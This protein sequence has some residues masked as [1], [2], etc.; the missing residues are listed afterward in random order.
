MV[1]VIFLYCL[2]WSHRYFISI[3]TI[4]IFELLN[5]LKCDKYSPYKSYYYRIKISY[6]RVSPCKPYARITQL[7]HKNAARVVNAW[8]KMLTVNFKDNIK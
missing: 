6:T 4:I 8:I 5:T 1:N 2:R 7:V 3:R